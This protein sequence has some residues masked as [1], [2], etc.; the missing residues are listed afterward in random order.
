M[1]EAF[2][3]PISALAA[4]RA[5]TRHEVHRAVRGDR[6]RPRS[7]RSGASS[8][9]RAR[10]ACSCEHAARTCGS[11]ATTT[12]R[13]ATRS[14]TVRRCC[15]AKASGPT[16]STA[17]R[18][19]IVGTRS[20]TPHGLADARELGGVSRRRRRHR[21]ERPRDRDR[22]RRAR[23]RAR[24]G[25]SRRSAW[26]RP[27]STSRTRGGTRRSY[28]RVREHGLVVGEHGYGVQPS[29]RA[30]PRPQPDHRR[31]RRGRRGR[32]GDGRAAVRASPRAT[33]SSTGATVCA[34]PGLAS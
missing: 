6:R 12:T 33:R 8:P 23:R 15:S 9:S 14:P 28:D 20:A 2:G 11:P 34:L 7:R 3:D 18:V 27:A 21:R 29:P 10:S 19:A 4:V 22:R 25:R 17:P 5:R 1:L 13:S 31:A 26:S 24:R 30:L 16:R 32:R